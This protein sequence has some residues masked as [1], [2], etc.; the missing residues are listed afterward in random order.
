MVAHV[1]MA[2]HQGHDNLIS[3]TM[4]V[5]G[6]IV[7]PTTF[8]DSYLVRVTTSSLCQYPKFGT[9]L[10]MFFAFGVHDQCIITWK[11]VDIYCWLNYY[12]S[13]HLCWKEALCFGLAAVCVSVHVSFCPK[14]LCVWYRYSELMD[15]HQTWQG[16]SPWIVDKLITFSRSRGQRSRSHKV[17]LEKFVYGIS[18]KVVKLSSPNLKW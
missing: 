14:S 10:A 7:P 11:N 13:A 5:V 3:Q 17:M 2:F 8:V 16:S 15:F 9:P 12:A 6:N 18:L 1:K 4:W